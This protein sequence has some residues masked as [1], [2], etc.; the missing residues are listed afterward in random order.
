MIKSENQE[1][2]HKINAQ[3][4]VYELGRIL[5]Q[6]RLQ[7]NLTQENLAKKA[8]LSRSAISEMENGRT[9]TSLITVVQVI[10]ALE[11]INL[12]DQWKETAQTNAIQ[13]IKSISRHR[14]RS[15]IRNSIQRKTE[16]EF[17]WL[18]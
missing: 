11:Q 15:S 1:D 6:I 10:K 7:Q 8:E 17:D 12:F 18:L 16:N 3:E 13:K 14:S 4:I 9:A 5:R 2:W